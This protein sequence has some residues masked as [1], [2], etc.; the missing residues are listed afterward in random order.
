MTTLTQELFEKVV[1]AVKRDH[2]FGVDPAIGPDKTAVV[3]VPPKRCMCWRCRLKSLFLNSGMIPSEEMFEV[4]HN[5][6]VCGDHI[7]DNKGACWKCKKIAQR[8]TR[9]F[10]FNVYGDQ[11]NLSGAIDAIHAARRDGSLRYWPK[12]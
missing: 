7:P 8:V 10:M 5:E 1:D 2:F 11:H 3:A 9:Q 12:E 4:A 6:C